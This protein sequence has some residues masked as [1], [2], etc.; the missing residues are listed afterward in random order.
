ML[1]L[2]GICFKCFNKLSTSTSVSMFLLNSASC[3]LR[4]FVVIAVVINLFFTRFI[5]L[6]FYFLL[7]YVSF[8][9][10]CFTQHRLRARP[11]RV[12]PSL[13]LKG[14]ALES[15]SK[16]EM[17]CRCCCCFSSVLC[18]SRWELF[19]YDEYLVKVTVRVIPTRTAA[20]TTSRTINSEKPKPEPQ[21]V[22]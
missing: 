10:L 18:G 1:T 19:N 5:L 9:K 13:P 17:I 8:F 7:L 15:H 20:T 11:L 16:R 21:L 12:H 14:F 2:Q 22:L 3:S 6:G 4:A